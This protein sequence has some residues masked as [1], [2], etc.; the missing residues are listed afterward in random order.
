MLPQVKWVLIGDNGQRDPEIFTE[1]GRR[2]PKNLAAV[3]IRTLLPLEHLTSH[4]TMKE[5]SRLDQAKLPEGV[6]L[7]FGEDGYHLNRS[8]S[9]MRFNK[10]LIDKLRA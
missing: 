1:F 7:I 5:L 10:Q 6:P 9:T 4:G 8:A 2:W 3:A